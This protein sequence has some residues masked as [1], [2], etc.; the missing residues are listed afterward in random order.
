MKTSFRVIFIL[1]I[2][3]SSF[4]LSQERGTLTT[5]LD[6]L[7]G[8]LQSLNR[9][10]KKET[11]IS[12][13]P[14]PSPSP[15]PA[16]TPEPSPTPQPEE[17]LTLPAIPE[18]EINVGYDEVEKVPEALAEEI[19]EEAK[20]EESTPLPKP[21]WKPTSKDLTGI[22]LES[23]IQGLKTIWKSFSVQDFKDAY[24]P[25]YSSQYRG[26]AAKV[27]KLSD[28][29]SVRG[30]LDARGTKEGEF[31]ANRLGKIGENKKFLDFLG[32]G[33]PFSTRDA[34]PRI[35]CAFSGGGYRA[36]IATSG[37]LKALEDLG[38]LD[39]VLNISTL[40]GSVWH[41]GPWTFYQ[42]D[43]K[44]VTANE[45]Q[46][47]LIQ[48][49]RNGT[50]NILPKNPV[51]DFEVK[52]FIQQV[53]WP[54]VIFSQIINSVDIYG[55]ALSYVLL[56]GADRFTKKLSDQLHIVQDGNHPWPSYTMV[57]MHNTALTDQK[58]QY[59]YIWYEL[60]P[61]S[62]R[63]LEENISIPSYGFG[64]TFDANG[65]TN[66]APEQSFGYLMG[67]CG[68]AFTVNL[69]DIFGIYF[70]YTPSD[71]R[72]KDLADAAY[73]AIATWFGSSIAS[74]RN[75]GEKMKNI[76]SLA[77][78]RNFKGIW[79]ETKSMALGPIMGIVFAMLLDWIVDIKIER[80][81]TIKGIELGKIST[82]VGTVRVSPAQIA[83]PF[84]GYTGIDQPWLTEKDYLTFVDA[85]IDYNIPLRPLLRPERDIDLIIIGDASD[86]SRSLTALY[87]GLKDIERVYGV[88]YTKMTHDEIMKK[89]K[90]VQR[91]GNMVEVYKP[92]QETYQKVKE[93]FK[94]MI[95]PHIIYVNF[96]KDDAL[97]AHAETSKDQA[98]L[99]V[100]HDNDLKNFNP[101]QCLKD[102]CSTFNFDYTEPQFKQLSGMAE[103]NMKA[104]QELLKG[105]INE[106]IE[107]RK[108]EEP[109][110][111]YLPTRKGLAA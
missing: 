31:V 105:L 46:E 98:L 17:E 80:D 95:P 48:K 32:Y 37:F 103:F 54:K 51:K 45:Y 109:E 97:I 70:G 38:V 76:L 57:S 71:N 101:E 106:R 60:D 73:T 8:Q 62:V 93:P 40:S 79:T 16:P 53:I 82:T 6:L 34:I 85:G 23:S 58:P 66:I 18:D 43:D 72:K 27:K 9:A 64:R 74:A 96:F 13:A 77:K 94:K 102:A 61:A 65:S 25:Q 75:A 63:N 14:T 91:I 10:L 30:Y 59:S 1:A 108:T 26:R 110:F 15:T 36:M 67:I 55:G 83:N 35:G 21:T 88:T 69:K 7:K 44:K 29:V 92:N 42:S 111:G 11:S 89:F 19:Q 33:H 22:I 28:E 78:E 100:I 90:N 99:K 84:K 4:C 3:Q 2:M 50:F 39:G 52:S 107:K 5:E 86:N 12:L 47:L 68:S 81:L 56:H 49:I 20:A 104:H 24:M 41:V 87:L